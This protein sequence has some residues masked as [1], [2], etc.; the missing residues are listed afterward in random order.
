MNN[1]FALSFGVS[2]V[3]VG[4]LN[5]FFET[6]NVILFGLSVSTTIFSIINMIVPNMK[7]NKAE[8]LYI[9]PFV[10]LISLFCYSNSLMKYPIVEGIVNGKIT[11]V[12]TFISFGFLFIS[13]YLN[14]K[15][16]KMEQKNFEMLQVI[17][18]YEYSNMILILI[19]DYLEN[20]KNRGIALDDESRNFL[21]QINDLCIEKSTLAD[22]DTTLLKLNKEEYSMQDFNDSYKIHND[23]INYEKM[24]NDHDKKIKKKGL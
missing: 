18:D 2:L 16:N 15:K 10:L 1:K 20:L 19:N 3:I 14:H 12:L 9:V 8:F 4:F 24:V 7:S 13:E 17:Q 5:I 22:I 11:N 6:S 21:N 23:T